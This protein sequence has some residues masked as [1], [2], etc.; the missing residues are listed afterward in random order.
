MQLANTA[1]SELSDLLDMASKNYF[2]LFYTL[3][4]AMC[5]EIWLLFQEKVM[6]FDDSFLWI[7]PIRYAIKL[8]WNIAS[9]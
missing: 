6:K 3:L 2:F 4:F 9:I 1:T 5:V 7:F 8:A